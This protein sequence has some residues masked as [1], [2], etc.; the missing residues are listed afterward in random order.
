ME[1]IWLRTD[2]ITSML[3]KMKMQSITLGLESDPDFA[4]PRD[5]LRGRQANFDLFSKQ[6]NKKPSFHCVIVKLDRHEKVFL[7]PICRGL[8]ASSSFSAYEPLSSL[9]SILSMSPGNAYRRAYLCRCLGQAVILC[10]TV[11]EQ[12]VQVVNTLLS[13]ISND[14]GCLRCSQL[15]GSGSLV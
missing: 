15:T 3:P 14:G 1:Q 7:V 11:T 5:P 9:T 8:Q 10:M 12:L 2:Q 4:S 13:L 6:T